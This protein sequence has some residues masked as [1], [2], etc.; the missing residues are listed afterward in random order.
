MKLLKTE[1]FNEN[2]SKDLKNTDELQVFLQFQI[3]EKFREIVIGVSICSPNG[4]PII[5]ILYND[6]NNLSEINPGIYEVSFVIPPCSLATGDYE[7]EFNL[8]IPNIIKFTSE[9]SKLVFSIFADSDYGNKFYLENN[10][11]FNSVSRPN[12]FKGIKKID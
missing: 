6:Y 7:M 5:G 12:W 8:S 9:K 3:G 2:R 11:N 10:Q 4:N 1:I